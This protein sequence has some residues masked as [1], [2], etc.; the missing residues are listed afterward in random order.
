MVFL[1]ENG[2]QQLSRNVVLRAAAYDAVK[3]K[4]VI[5]IQ[6]MKKE[7]MIILLQ[8][9]VRLVNDVTSMGNPDSSLGIYLTTDKVA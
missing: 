7:C 9:K 2:S 8:N 5:P 1:Q 6:E 3:K 4:T